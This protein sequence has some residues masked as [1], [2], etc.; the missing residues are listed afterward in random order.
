MEIDRNN[1]KWIEILWKL[2]EIF[3]NR[4]EIELK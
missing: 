4:V 1:W 3:G 2:I